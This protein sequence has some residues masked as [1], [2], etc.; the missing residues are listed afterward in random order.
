LVSKFPNLH[1]KQ[2]LERMSDNSHNHNSI[3]IS[4]QNE[5]AS[6]LEADKIITEK[7]TMDS[8]SPISRNKYPNI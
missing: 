8:F 6:L 5:Q 7:K 1:P 4:Q 3:A 2:E